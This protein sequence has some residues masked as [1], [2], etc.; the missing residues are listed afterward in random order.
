MSDKSSRF[1]E[2]V[3]NKIDEKFLYPWAIDAIR[4]LSADSGKKTPENLNKTLENEVYDDLGVWTI[5]VLNRRD[6]EVELSK[7]L[8]MLRNLAKVKWVKNL[9]LIHLNGW[10]DNT[11]RERKKARRTERAKREGQSPNIVPFFIG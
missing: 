2:L 9:I 11:K 5:D 6:S 3:D 4:R 7:L 8:N 1:K 10:L